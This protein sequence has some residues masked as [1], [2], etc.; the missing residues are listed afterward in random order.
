M[1]SFKKLLK[2]Y[3]ARRDG[4]IRFYPF[5]ALGR[6]W[7][8]EESQV[9]NLER[10]LAVFSYGPLL[11]L[12]PYFLLLQRDHYLIT[13][14]YLW[15]AILFIYAL[16][17]I[18]VRF[19]ARSKGGGIR[20]VPEAVFLRD[21]ALSQSPERLRWRIAGSVFTAVVGFIALLGTIGSSPLGALGFA[22]LSVFFGLMSLRLLRV[23]RIQKEL[24]PH[25]DTTAVFD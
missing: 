10:C 13:N 6:G 15:G 20:R 16:Y 19:F 21:M 7:V 11:L 2:R 5:G 24:G 25:T 14:H 17:W 18:A 1:F 22:A 12:V 4:E 8:V 3:F 9:P 23:L